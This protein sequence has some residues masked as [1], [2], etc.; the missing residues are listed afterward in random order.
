MGLFSGDSGSKDDDA[1]GEAPGLWQERGFVASAIVVGAVVVC[2][3]VWFFA[4]DPGTPATQPTASPSV[5]EPTEQPTGEPTVPP[6]TP[7]DEPTPTSTPSGPPASGRGGCYTKNPD[8]GRPRVAP[9]GVTW[10]FEANM[11]IP[12][13]Q[14]GGP[15]VTD[16]SGVLSCFA[17][18]PTGAVLAAMVTLGQI[19]NPELTDRVLAARIAPGPG[20]NRAISEARVTRTPRNEGDASQFTGFKVIDYTKDRAIVYIAVRLDSQKIAALPVTLTWS[21]GDWRIVLQEDGSF[22]GSV[23]PDVLRSLD[24]YIRF[25]GA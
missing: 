4:R 11:L 3:L 16:E 25:R 10:Q 19:R 15:A 21:R 6:A 9:S 5:V 23:Q 13:Q 14:E 17:H 20:R 24:G 18:S 12:L 22:N 7:T 8:Q 2:L 1:G